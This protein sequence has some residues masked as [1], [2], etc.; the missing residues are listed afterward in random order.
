MIRN[1]IWNAQKFLPQN[2]ITTNVVAPSFIPSNNT[3]LPQTMSIPPV[4]P[5]QHIKALIDSKF[6]F[7][8]GGSRAMY[9]RGAKVIINDDTDYDYYATYSKEIEDFL[10]K[11]GY[12]SLNPSTPSSYYDDECVMI[13]KNSGVDVVLRKD[14]KFYKS[15]FDNINPDMYVKHLW[16]RNPE[17]D[18]SKIQPLFNE[19]FKIAHKKELDNAKKIFD[20]LP[21]DAYTDIEDIPF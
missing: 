18:R 19:M 21:E 1:Y 6:E 17:C 8:L 7:Y 14:A 10:D 20:K 4:A 15:V 9:K 3:Q 2:K 12:L 5:I 11:W 13:F 16:K